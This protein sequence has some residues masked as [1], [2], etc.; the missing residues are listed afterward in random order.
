MN[1]GTNVPDFS[2]LGKSMQADLSRIVSEEIEALESECNRVSPERKKSFISTQS[3][4]ILHTE[5]D[6]TKFTLLD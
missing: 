3:K 2:V 5:N 4:S 6:D 1:Q